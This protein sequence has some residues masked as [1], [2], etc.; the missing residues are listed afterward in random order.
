M[1]KLFFVMNPCAGQ[2]RAHRVLADIINIFNRADYE[3]TVYMTACRGDAIDAVRSHAEGTDLVVCCGG[4]G[5]F[6]EAV[7]GMMQSGIRVPIGYIP[8]GS[9]ND[10][11]SS[12]GLPSDCIKAAEKIAA[13]TPVAYDIGAFCGR[14]FS[15][16]AS[17]GAFTKASYATPQS[18]KNAIGHLA[19]ILGGISE[20]SQI[21]KTHVKFTLD[22]DEVL[23]D[24]YLFGAI[25]N[26][27]SMGGVLKL[28]PTLVDMQDGKFEILL[29]RAPKNALELAECVG[30][31]QSKTYNCGMISFRSASRIT[32]E[33]P[34]DMPW[35]LDG[36]KE[37]GHTVARVENCHLALHL[38][39]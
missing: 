34:A 12:L 28:D 33:A 31:L 11:A 5:T 17:F 22:E 3:V 37:E 39:V 27:T 4:D 18:V 38:V 15:Y 10:F 19:Y 16:V 2:K 21:H 36:E 7:T 30:A 26:S 20:L 13:G 9:T 35:V 32:V 29:I 14:Y 8:A 24:D 6:N 25:A 1:K 23:E